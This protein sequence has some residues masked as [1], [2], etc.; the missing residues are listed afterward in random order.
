[1]EKARRLQ[2]TQLKQ[3]WSGKQKLHFSPGASSNCPDHRG[4]LLKK[5][6][7][8]RWSGT[9]VTSMSKG[10][11]MLWYFITLSNFVTSISEIS[12]SKSLQRP[13]CFMVFP[14][15]FPLVF[16]LVSDRPAILSKARHALCGSWRWAAWT[17]SLWAGHNSAQ[18]GP[19][20][21]QPTMRCA[22]FVAVI[23]VLSLSFFPHVIPGFCCVLLRFFWLSS[24]FASRCL[25]SANQILRDADASDE[26]W[27][28]LPWGRYFSPCLGLKTSEGGSIQGQI[29]RVFIWSM[30]V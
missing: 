19:N 10:I 28:A 2:L 29:C 17:V 6:V 14:L 27:F 22:V 4:G 11:A 15:L 24:K 21:S 13:M 1:M 16:P 23:P 5:R 26:S 8:L 18:R 25:T 20:R 30:I 7:W 9:E 3:H 12:L